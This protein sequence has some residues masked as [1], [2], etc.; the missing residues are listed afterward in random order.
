MKYII[1]ESSFNPTTK[2]STL[3]VFGVESSD[4]GTYTCK[5]INL[6]SSDTSSGVL[7]VDG[8]FGSH[9]MNMFRGGPLNKI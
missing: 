9:L 5:A 4:S 1:S 3:A 6:V 7:S 8:K 2:N